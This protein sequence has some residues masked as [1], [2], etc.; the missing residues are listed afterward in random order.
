MTPRERLLAA[1]ERR[2]PAGVPV[3]LGGTGT[4]TITR[5]A[6]MNLR[7]S[8]GLP[9]VTPEF[10]SFTAQSVRPH[11]DILDALRIDTRGV[12]PRGSSTFK[13]LMHTEG[14]YEHFSD[15]SGVV[16]RRPVD[17]GFYFD[18]YQ[19]PLTGKDA[20]E[21]EAYRFPWGGD[22]A[23]AAGLREE[24]QA[25]RNAGFPVILS[26]SLGRGILH[27]GTALFGFEDYFTRFYLEEA[28]IDSV[29][30]R[31]LQNKIEFYTVMLGEIGD[32][33]DVVTEADDLGTQ[34]GPF[35]SPDSYRKRIKPYH[36]R[37]FAEIRRLAPEVKIFFHSCGS[38]AEFIPDL[39]DIG[40]DALNPL[41]LSA[42]GMDPV[43]LKR[44]YGRDICFW[45]GGVDTQH[46][47][48]RG[49]ID[50]VKDETRR[51][52]DQWLPGGGYVF[53]AVHNIQD[54]VPPEHITAVFEVLDEYR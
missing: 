39:I 21:I 22:P 50:E 23:R 45:G 35:I 32:L 52:L 44:E 47:L 24:C 8:L 10:I 34:R 38:I 15:E 4:S 46:V 25:I 41:Q 43:L 13:P 28:L 30:E 7:S 20:S 5:Q 48:P 37:L 29:T 19:H 51:R 1:L 17:G 42:D 36:R 26:Q 3:D 6:Y 9:E 31:I 11:S 16:Y 27:E 54:D 12:N 2:E 49:S 14:A 53:A 40:A 33:V 18:M